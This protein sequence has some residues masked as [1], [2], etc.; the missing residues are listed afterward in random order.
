MH[1]R[2]FA[3]LF[4]IFTAVTNLVAAPLS[5]EKQVILKDRKG[6]ETVIGKVHFEP[7]DNEK[8]R[9][10]LHLDHKLFKDY[11]LSMKEMKCL[12]GPELWC[13]IPYPYAQPREVSATDLRWLEHDLMFMFKKPSEFGANF[14]NGIYYSIASEGGKLGGS[15]MAVDLNMLASPPDDLA[16]PPVNEGL[17][18]EIELSQRWL[19]HIEIR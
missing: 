4:L 18:D 14:W 11:F 8:S 1:Q 12:E 9:Y 19:P 10:Q 15:A 2:L 13:H 6:G 17:L 7:L 5:G 16:I 3:S